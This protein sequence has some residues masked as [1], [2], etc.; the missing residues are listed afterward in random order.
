MQKALHDLF[1]LKLNWPYRNPEVPL[2]HYFFHDNCHGKGK[3]DYTRTGSK[4]S[5]FDDVFTA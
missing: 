4:I 2:C 1:T 3:T 5:R